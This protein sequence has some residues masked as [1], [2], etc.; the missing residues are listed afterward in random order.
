MIPTTTTTPQSCFLLEIGSAWHRMA[1]SPDC[2]TDEEMQDLPAMSDHPSISI[3]QGS[4]ESR[5]D[6]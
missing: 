1:Q 6:V 5:Q 2:T 3:W 4:E